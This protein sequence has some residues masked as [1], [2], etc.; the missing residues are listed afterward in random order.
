MKAASIGAAAA[1]P[2]SRYG[3][4]L[5]AAIAITAT[6]SGCVTPGGP[7]PTV[8]GAPGAVAEEESPCE[9]A[10]AK[11][12]DAA[13]G[14]VAVGTL[15]YFL[16]GKK[17]APTAIGAV[18]GGL[19]GF[20]VGKDMDDRRCEQWKIAK[21]ANVQVHF[22]DVVVPKVN[23]QGVQENVRVGQVATWGGAGHFE[24]G[25][26][27]LTPDAQ[28]YFRAVADT[29]AKQRDDGS[30]NPQDKQQLEAQRRDRRILLVGHTDDIGS[31]AANA[32]LSEA[33]AKAVGEVFR[34]AGVDPSRLYFQ[35]AGEK[36]PKADNR[37]ED[38]R[39]QNRRVEIVEVDNEAALANYLRTRAPKTEFYRVA[40]AAA[41]AVAKPAGAVKADAAPTGES[42]LN[43]ALDESAPPPA[44]AKAPSAPATTSA[45]PVPTAQAAALASQPATSAKAASKAKPNRNEIDFG[46]VPAAQDQGVTTQMIGGQKQSTA[47]S[48]SS[49]FGISS[50]F[51]HDSVFLASCADDHPRVGGEVK[52]LS[53]GKEFEYRNRDF[54]PGLF[55][56]S[57]AGMVNGH[58]VGM[59]DIAVLRDGNTPVGKPQVLVFKNY[60]GGADNQRKPDAQLGTDV[61]VYPGNDALLYR[62]FVAAD[63][64]QAPLQ[65]VDLVFPYQPPFGAKYGKV[66]FDKR[67]QTYAADFA[68]TLT[69]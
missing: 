26:A 53:D 21:A 39:A 56:T 20:L 5:T 52:R 22:D 17:A 13:I 47:Q 10:N 61:N 55:R 33:R 15:T 31:S 37:T 43:R 67:G 7:Q 6:V 65:C 58:M 68:P 44:V 18:G 34:A 60:G 25:S 54:V 45:P 35:G 28:K 57:Y 38:G 2:R 23:Q 50:V 8:T 30:V 51:A 40:T 12:Y 48:V 49:Y 24:F 32:K 11:Y 29:Y 46:G 27:N 63:Q 9:A 4:R 3:R 1:A 64:P 59:T 42:A 19:I 66:Y 41:P 36:F 62:V 14:A 69:R 16:G